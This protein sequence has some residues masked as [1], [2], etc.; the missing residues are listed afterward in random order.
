MKT[1]IIKIAGMHC[2]ACSTGVE[3]SLKKVAGV[4]GAQVN[5]ASNSAQVRYDEQ[6]TQIAELEQAITRMSFSVIHEGA[7]EASAQEIYRREQENMRHRLYIALAFLAVLLYVAMV[8]ML[9]GNFL[10]L[11][12]VPE[13]Q[14]LA[15]AVVQLVLLLPILYAGKGFFVGGYLTLKNKMPSM[16]TLVALGSLAAIVYSLYSI[17]NIYQGQVHAIHQLYFESAGTII[18]FVLL[19][20]TLESSAKARTGDAIQALVNLVPPTGILWQEE[21]ETEIPVEEIM[22][23]D[24]LVVKP[25]FSV[26]VDGVIIRGQASINESMLTGE[27]VPVSKG[28]G[29]QVFGGTLLVNGQ[30]LFKASKVGADTA[31]S[32]IT[33]MVEE[34][35]GTK[36]SIARMADKIAGIF[37][38]V[39]LVI[40]CVSAL[41]WF[42]TTGN[43]NLAL[44][45]FVS[46][47]VIA[48]PCALGLATPVAIMVAIGRGAKEGILYRNAQALEVA[49]SGTAVLMD[50]TGTITEGVMSVTD[51]VSYECSQQEL[52]Q[53]A[54]SVES[55]SAH[56]L[57]EGIRRKAQEQQIELLSITQL[58]EKVG[59]GIRGASADQEIRIGKHEFMQGVAIPPAFITRATALAAEGKTVLFVAVN[60]SFAGLLAV[61][62]VLRPNAPQVVQRLQQMGLEVVMLT[63]DNPQTA[64]YIAGLAGIKLVEAQLLP[65][66]KVRIVKKYQQGQQRV[67]MVGDGINDAPALAQADLG[68]AIGSGTD[69]ALEAADVVLASRDLAQLVTMI[70]LSKLTLRNVKENLGWA[71]GYNIIG[72]PVAAGVLYV[73]GGPL[74]NP[75]L[76]AAAM[77]LSSVSVVANALRLNRQK[78]HK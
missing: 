78:L 3:R 35:Q 71:F 50:K 12:M 28:P 57:A 27:S 63:G 7:G 72:I 55:H 58:E 20:K 54:A 52:L 76:A 6:R 30:L 59:W 66:D 41:L 14:P 40:A 68:V 73:W 43:I 26:P 64:A 9:P 32:H 74:L 17:S 18:T 36:P 67:I 5:L 21:V 13:E 1:V 19:G 31:L 11:L 53:W 46:V 48:C 22:V 37:V 24:C 69:V 60:Q 61:A 8:P 23:D 47:L 56:P 39:V 29:E 16:D 70:E 2:A 77:S 42:V 62:D 15:F 45:I 49:A 65:A 44:R 51:I 75:M 4:I 10:P 25:G 38:P 34:A 33:Q